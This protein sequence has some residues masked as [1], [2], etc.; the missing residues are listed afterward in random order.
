M[1]SALTPDCSRMAT[2]SDSVR[3]GR[4]SSRTLSPSQTST[5][6]M[7]EKN[8]ARPRVLSAVSTSGSGVQ[9]HGVAVRA[10]ERAR[11]R[12]Q[13]VEHELLLT[14]ATALGCVTCRERGAHVGA[15]LL[16]VVAKQV[17]GK[18]AYRAAAGLVGEQADRTAILEHNQTA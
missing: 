8:S 13:L 17:E 4:Q 2:R 18:P 16:H 10:G 6:R 15:A 12:A 1:C 5:G 11:V 14:V 7:P 3:S 9:K